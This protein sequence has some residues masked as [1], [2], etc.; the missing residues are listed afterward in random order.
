[1]VL[2]YGV[3]S[4]SC[5]MHFGKDGVSY[6]IFNVTLSPFYF[7][8]YYQRKQLGNHAL[9]QEFYLFSAE[10]TEITLYNSHKFHEVVLC[11]KSW[12]ISLFFKICRNHVEHYAELYPSL[13]LIT[14]HG[15]K[16]KTKRSTSNHLKIFLYHTCT[17][18][19]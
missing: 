2:Y 8:S 3:P 4:I 7:H 1:M 12:Q 17:T 13:N 15:T 6:C 10:F 5:A 9:S 19:Q 14:T 11:T 16:Y 18:K